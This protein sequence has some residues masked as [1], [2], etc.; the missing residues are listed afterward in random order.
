MIFHMVQVGTSFFSAMSQCTRLTDRQSDRQ[1]AIPRVAL[2]AVAR[3]EPGLCYI[4]MQYSK[5]LS[6]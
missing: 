2:H 5:L 6:L 1:K 3:Q 4:L